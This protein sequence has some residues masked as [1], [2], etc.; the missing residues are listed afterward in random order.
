MLEFVL[1]LTIEVVVID[2][3]IVSGEGEFAETFGMEVTEQDD[4]YGLVRSYV[5]IDGRGRS[6]SF[7]AIYSFY[8]SIWIVCDGLG[9]IFYGYALAKSFSLSQYRYLHLIMG[10][11]HL[12]PLALTFGS[13]A[14]LLVG[15]RVFDAARETIRATS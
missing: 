7:Q 12:P 8:R 14:I 2:D 3:V 15:R 9:A 4:I 11:L 6:R 1:L 13:V 5:H 10:S